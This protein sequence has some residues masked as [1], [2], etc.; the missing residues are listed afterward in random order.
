MDMLGS[1]LWDVWNSVG[2][3]SVSCQS[4]CLV[5][6]LSYSLLISTSPTGCLLIWLLVLLLRPY[7]F[8]RNFTQKGNRNAFDNHPKMHEFYNAFDANIHMV[9]YSY[10]CKLCTWRCETRELFA[11]SAGITWWKEAFPDW[12]WFR[13]PLVKNN[14]ISMW[15]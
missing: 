12:S 1:S 13:Y 9:S 14:F 4:A 15:R 11:W 5:H 6:M 7:Q 10:H 3:A 8:L 2:Q